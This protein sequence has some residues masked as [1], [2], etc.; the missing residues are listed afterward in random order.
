MKKKLIDDSYIDEY[1]P[2]LNLIYIKLYTVANTYFQ[3]V[4]SNYFSLYYF[5]KTIAFDKQICIKYKRIFI[6]CV[7]LH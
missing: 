3:L 5:S 6:N 7:L 1:K 2:A 4:A